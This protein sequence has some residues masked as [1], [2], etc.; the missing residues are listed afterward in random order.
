M[1]GKFYHEYENGILIKTVCLLKND[2]GQIFKGV[3]RTNKNYDCP[4]KKMGRIIAYGRAIKSS[5]FGFVGYSEPINEKDQ[6]LA[7]SLNEIYVQHT[8]SGKRISNVI[9]G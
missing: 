5:K 9:N 6:R 1:K 8:R 2:K 4:S 7:L 3:A